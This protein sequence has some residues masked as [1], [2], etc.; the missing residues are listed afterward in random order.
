M[1]VSDS[2]VWEGAGRNAARRLEALR[3]EEI[4]G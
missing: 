3:E 2:D 1:L 4:E